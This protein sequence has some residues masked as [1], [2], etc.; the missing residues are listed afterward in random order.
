MFSASKTAAVVNV[1]SDA[2]FNYVTMLLHGDG[3]NGAQNNTF[4]DSSTNNFTITRNG[5]TTQGSFSPYGSNWSN[6]FDGTGDYLSNSSAGTNFGTGS[7]TVE[8]W[9]FRSGAGPNPTVGEII[10]DFRTTD[11]TTGN[12]AIVTRS[13]GQVAVYGLPSGTGF[14]EVGAYQSGWNHVAVGANGTN[15][16]VWINGTRVYNASGNSYNYT[17]SGLYIGA[18]TSAVGGYNFN[19]YIS[20]FRAVK[21]TDVYGITNTTITVPTAPLTAITNTVV[22]TCQSNRFI[23]NSSGALVITRNGD[24]SVQRF[25]PFGTYTAYSTSVIG[26]SGYFDGSGDYLQCAY[27][28]AFALSSS[29]F[30]IEA[31]VNTTDTT[32][33]YPSIIGRWQSAGNACW[34]FRP[35]STDI[36]NFFVFVY[37]TNGTTALSVNSNTVINDG[38]WHHLVAVRSGNNFALFVDGVRKAT[39]SFTGITIFN[40]TSAPLYVG[41]DPYGS[42]YYTGYQSNTRLVN[43]TA[44][45]DPTQ[46]TLTVPTAPLTAVTNTA[47]LANFTNGAIF[48]NAMMNDLETVGNAQISTSVKKY[49]TGS[50]SFDGSGDWL[51]SNAPANLNAFGTSDFTI[52]CWFYL[53]STAS[54]QIFL[55]FRSS[56]SD[57]AGVLYFNGTNA[58]WYV[59]MASKISG[60]TF[61]TSVWYHIAVCRSGT[62]TKMFVNGTQVGS[63]YTDTNNYICP[64]GRPYIGALSDGTGTLYLNGYV[65]DVRIT[66]GYARYTANFTSPIEA[67]PDKGPY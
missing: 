57:V 66:K 13:N 51:T 3:T 20:N 43:G 19:G 47:F 18:A 24:V 40:S 52:E 14:T 5:N 4:I 46:T 21:G 64:S 45:Y 49:G 62:S 26:G 27:N 23:D 31:W 50:L 55:D 11:T 44:V 53:N 38:A 58:S 34:D 37:T 6:F 8:C 36:G 22:L 1:P 54:A 29:D 33:N 30:T 25:N 12:F 39:A 59:S 32:S 41:Y 65:D 7:F 15:F 61:S 10:V 28:S 2:Q 60:G 63:T 48:D 67:F 16:S 17:Q 42:T 35:R 9:F 56:A